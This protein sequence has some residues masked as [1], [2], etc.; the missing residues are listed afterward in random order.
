MARTSDLDNYYSKINGEEYWTVVQNGWI[1]K[2]GTFSDR[3]N[4]F[5][6]AGNLIT[7]TGYDQ[8]SHQWSDYN[9]YGY[10]FENSTIYL[11]LQ[12]GTRIDV[13]TGMYLMIWTVKLGDQTYYTTDSYDRME[14]VTDNATGEMV[15][16]NYFTTL[17]NQKIYFDWN[18]N[19]ATWMEELHIPITGT[20]YTRMIPYT[21]QPTSVF[22][23]VYIYNISI[24][25]QISDPG[26][27]WVYYENGSEVPAW[28]DFKVY[29]TPYGPGTRY[30][31]GW[32]DDMWVSYSGYIPGAKAPWNTE[33]NV[34]YMTTLS[35]TRIYSLQ[36]FGWDG[37]S[38]NGNKQWIFK[39][40]DSVGGNRTVS[41]EEGGYCIYLNDTIKIDVTTAY[42]YGGM[43]NQY[44]IMKNGTT[45]N[46][47]W[48]DWPIGQYTTMVGTQRYVFRGVTT[49]YNFTDSG[50]VYNIGDPFNFDYRS[51]LTPSVY[52][53][54]TISPGSDT[55][56][57]MNATSESILHDE[58]GYYLINATDQSRIDLTLV[59]D[60][61]NL[62]TTSRKQVF[63]NEF[64]DYYARFNVTI[65]GVE[66][67]VLD[68]NPI[69][70][71][72][73]GEWDVEQNMY[74]YP[75]SI[76]LE[77]GG[78][79]YNVT[80]FQEGSGYWR[81]DIR[82]RRLSTITL[83]G[84]SYEVQE[85]GQWKPSYQVSIDGETLD[86][87][88]DTMSIYKQHTMWGNIYT[89]MLTDL[90]ISTVRQVNDIIVGTPN[91]G[92][93]GIKAFTIVDETGAIDLDGDLAT[94]D[95]QYFVRRVHSGSN[96]RNETADRMWVDIIWNPN[97]SRLG[98]EV[99]V[100]AWMGK[101]HVIWTSE[102][103]ESYIW[104]YASNMTGVS[105]AEMTRIQSVVL[106]N[107]TGQAKPGYWDISYMARN[108][109]WADVLAQAQKE[110]WDWITDS[111]N[112]WEWLWFGTDQNY[113][114]DMISGTDTQAANVGLQYEFAGLTLYND[115]QQTHY[116]MP[117]GVGNITFTTPGEPYGDTNATGSIVLPLNAKI[118]FG[119]SYDN[120][121]GT[122]FP[123]SDQ[124]SMW[125][126]WDRP[127]YGADFES[128][129][130][131]Q[132][133]RAADRLFRRL[134]GHQG[135]EHQDPP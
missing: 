113:N 135:A 2:Y 79:T 115:T 72:W 24:P 55:W 18:T 21:W 125:G 25:E 4:L 99:H 107:A 93:W 61:W 66:Y 29:G 1:L 86:V 65:D 16:K 51:F 48:L 98:D 121:N 119:V 26:H 49:Y 85:Q 95:D 89:W 74:R 69:M 97:S 117:E 73:N 27:T 20:N 7:T 13:N 88:M 33:V 122:L 12:N 63:Q 30:N 11:S 129:N 133:I 57:W 131:M 53:T 68:P 130:F 75:S 56:L 108:Q 54:P 15:Y 80:L 78:V 58:T 96:L 60:W 31:Y 112:E 52:Q 64:N 8:M 10:D 40:D 91:Y 42:P 104:Y 126:W 22:D 100:G 50:A 47:Q 134:A 19:P 39:N 128:P 116:F 101:M 32:N 114:V 81:Q 84:E 36:N 94:V 83:N 110:N 46:V 23:Q 77:L 3:S 59:D 105:N 34:G 71:R 111:T 82:I 6:E 102:W 41:V 76:S 9:R 92:M 106:D 35:G 70:N 118:D 37:N 124:R 28:T 87:Q 62:S 123:Y 90:G 17:D 45:L 44:L 67:F 132:A 43:P 103:S 5:D 127:V 120:I 109:T 14:S 38:W